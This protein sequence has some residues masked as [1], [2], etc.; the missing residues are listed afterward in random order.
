MEGNRIV[1][2]VPDSAHLR[3][4]AADYD[5][6]DLNALLDEVQGYYGPSARVFIHRDHVHAQRP[7]LN[8]PYYGRRGTT[9][10]RR[11]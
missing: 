6:P 8:A 7:G 1:G 9:G 5:G 2:G 11:D 10:L 3:G 4:D